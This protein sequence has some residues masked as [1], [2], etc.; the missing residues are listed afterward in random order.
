MAAGSSMNVE[1]AVR[2]LEASLFEPDTLTGCFDRVAEALRL[3]LF[4]LTD[5]SG[6]Q[7]ELVGGTASMAAF[8]SYVHNQVHQWDTWMHSA[9]RQRGS[10]R[11]LIFDRTVVPKEARRR[12]QYY[13]DYCPQWDIVSHCAWPLEIDNRSFAFSMMRGEK[14][15][16]FS[17][18]DEAVIHRLMPV[19]NRTALLLNEIRRARIHGIAAGLEAAGRAAVLLDQDGRVSLITKDAE[20]ML[21]SEIFVRANVLCSNDKTVHAKLVAIAEAVRRRKCRGLPNLVLHR[22][23]KLPLLV[24]PSPVCGAGLDLLPGARLILTLIDLEE[25][26]RLRLE[27]ICDVL[28]LTRTEG[29]LACWLTGGKSVEEIAFLKGGAVSSVRQTLKAIFAKTGTHSQPELVALVSKLA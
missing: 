17:A 16:D 11:S 5:V 22:A 8:Q 18:E 12:D 27:T 24:M 23:D 6:D 21:G 15:G 29:Q 1:S 3:R 20:T 26:P 2:A 10:A 4:H 13:Q 9:K 25:P 7:I 28:G 14:Q 19:A